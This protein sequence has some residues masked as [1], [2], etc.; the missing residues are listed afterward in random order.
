MKKLK[1]CSIVFLFLAGSFVGN[2]QH[3]LSVLQPNI[4]KLDSALKQT[5]GYETGKYWNTIWSR[6]YAL[7]DFKGLRSIRDPNV[8]RYN[9]YSEEFP[10]VLVNDIPLVFYDIA[11]VEFERIDSVVFNKSFTVGMKLA[12]PYL[13]YG[14]L[15]LKAELKSRDTSSWDSGDKY[16][17][18]SLIECSAVGLTS[19]LDSVLVVTVGLNRNQCYNYYVHNRFR[20]YAEHNFPPLVNPYLVPNHIFY[21]PEINIKD[22]IYAV[23]VNK[24][25]MNFFDDESWENAR[26]K[27]GIVTGIQKTIE[28][29]GDTQ[30]NSLTKVRIDITA[31]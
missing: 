16:N 14:V 20:K 15:N 4:R 3:D 18:K 10:L 24:L 26:L 7:D 23:Y 17:L 22:T 6:Y 9:L 29:Q 8:V 5:L 31:E 13:K 1:R 28:Q 2:A 30:H 25:P 21:P 12:Y 11:N 19:F 27:K